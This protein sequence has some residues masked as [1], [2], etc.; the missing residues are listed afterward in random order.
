[1]ND[2]G[3]FV[4]NRALSKRNDLEDKIRQLIAGSKSLGN[5][6]ELATR[7]LNAEEIC[8]A[9]YTAQLV[10]NSKHLLAHYRSTEVDLAEVRR[11]HSDRVEIKLVASACKEALART[12]QTIKYATESKQQIDRQIETYIQE[13]ATYGNVSVF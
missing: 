9:E 10:D 5:E 6:L 12:R 8:M 1:M 3:L 7:K 4:V 13:L 11:L 2:P